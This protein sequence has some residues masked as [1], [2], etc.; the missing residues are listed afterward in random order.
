MPIAA[1]KDRWQAGMC[2][3]ITG[4]TSKGGAPFN[5]VVGRISGRQKEDEGGR[6]KLI[7]HT[8]KG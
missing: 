2:A 7:I 8:P 5:N 3:E 4:L 6:Y 1:E